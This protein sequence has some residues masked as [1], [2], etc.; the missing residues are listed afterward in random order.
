L[1][2]P[3]GYSEAVIRRIDN[4]I[5]KRTMTRRHAMGKQ[6][7]TDNKRLNNTYPTKNGK[8]NSGAPYF[9]RNSI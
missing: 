1:K 8:G 4:T 6:Y 5:G 2:I 3:K 9:I 7:Y